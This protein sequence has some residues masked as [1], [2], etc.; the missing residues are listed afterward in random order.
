RNRVGANRD[1]CLTIGAERT[2]GSAAWTETQNYD[3]VSGNAAG[4]GGNNAAIGLQRNGTAAAAV[5]RCGDN[6]ASCREGGLARAVACVAA[7]CARY[8]AID[9]ACFPRYDD[10]AVGLQ[11]PSRAPAGGSQSCAHHTVAAECGIQ[12]SIRVPANECDGFD[13]RHSSS[14]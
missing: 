14:N 5:V 8:I 7:D 6:Q 11:S 4:T 1:E 3:V 2:V 10:L 9:V 13:V 12:R